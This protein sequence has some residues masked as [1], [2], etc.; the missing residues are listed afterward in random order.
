MK[1]LL[2]F[3]WVLMLVFAALPA[4]SLADKPHV[5]YNTG[6]IEDLQFIFGVPGL[7]VDL[8]GIGIDP[9]YALGI[10]IRTSGRELAII[11]CKENDTAD[12][13]YRGEYGSGTIIAFTRKNG[14]I[15]RVRIPMVSAIL[16][17]FFVIDGQGAIAEALANPFTVVAPD[18][19]SLVFKAVLGDASGTVKFALIV[20]RCEV[21]FV[22]IY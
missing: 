3:T 5:F 2:A 18:D 21:V 1:R 22:G 10:N 20:V 6:R 14:E 4:N 13:L 12:Y 9:L 7:P 19:T 15:V 16:N 17:E 8:S 11:D